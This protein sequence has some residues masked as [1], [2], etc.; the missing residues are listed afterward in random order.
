MSVLLAAISQSPHL[1]LTDDRA[2]VKRS[3]PWPEADD[4]RSR[5]I[6]AKGIPTSAEL[7]PLLVFFARFGDVKAVR[8]RR[9]KDDRQRKKSVF[10]EY[11]TEETVKKILAQHS[12]TEFS[13]E[14]QKYEVHLLNPNDYFK[15]KRKSGGGGDNKKQKQKDKKRG[16]NNSNNDVGEEKKK[17]GGD[18][19]DGAGGAKK[20]QRGGGSQLE[21]GT[22]VHF[23]GIGV[24]LSRAALREVFEQHCNGN[25][26]GVKSVDYAHGATEGYA[27]FSNEVQAAFFVE[28]MRTQNV[29]VDGKPC[30]ARVLSAE[31]T[32]KYEE[33]V[34]MFQQLKKKGPRKGKGAQKKKQN[35]SHQVKE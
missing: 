22:V 16:N 7:D 1:T 33:R 11:D 24:R 14:S 6:L 18:D 8:F 23:E 29:E 2:R 30:K 10:V 12:K 34:N 17:D 9:G 32:R 21:D 15:N 27:V 19:D 25:G 4:G 3:T 35:N 28:K 31:E 26:E 13:D 20:K 5:S